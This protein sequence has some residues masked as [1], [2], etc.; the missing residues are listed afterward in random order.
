MPVSTRTD[1]AAIN[2]VIDAQPITSSRRHWWSTKKDLTCACGWSYRVAGKF[3]G[4][5]EANRWAAVGEIPMWRTLEDIRAG[6]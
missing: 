4:W 1:P 5:M 6:R 3:S 2:A